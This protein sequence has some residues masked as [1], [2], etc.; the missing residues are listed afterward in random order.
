M[1]ENFT[2]WDHQAE[3]VAKLRDAVRRG[4]KR[5]VLSAPCGAGKTEIA[6]EVT[7]STRTKGNFAAFT[8]PLIGLID[9]TV[10][11]F[12]KRGVAAEQIGVMQ[13]KHKRANEKRS[14]SGLLGPDAHRAQDISARQRRAD[15]RVPPSA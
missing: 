7:K 11:R 10:A 3:S 1:D 15:R 12:E 5:I 6:T 13:A 9:Q 14:D 8:V 2:L 4:K